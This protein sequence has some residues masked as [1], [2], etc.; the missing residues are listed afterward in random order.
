MKP[1]YDHD[2]I[3]IYHGDCREI[4][5][6]VGQVDCVVTSPPYDNL[7]V[8]GGH[9]FDFDGCASALVPTISEG[10]VIVWVVADEA[11]DGDESGSSMRQAL[12]FKE[13][14]M[15]LHD[16][17]IWRKLNGGANGSNFAYLQCWE[18]M[19]VFSKG[20][21]KTTN[22]IEDRRNVTP[23][24]A[25]R[26]APGRRFADGTVKPDRVV[27]RKEFGRRWNVWDTPVGSDE[28]FGHPAVFPVTLAADHIR[29]WC[30]GDGT[31]LDPFAGSG[32]T[33]RAAKDLGRRAIGIEIE[34]RYCE[35]AAERL[36]QE[37]LAL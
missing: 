37:V 19:F 9:S 34:E 13:L 17:M 16:T 20:A 24:R 36:S 10:G 11:K 23:P 1:Y 30:G 3:T 25:K 21:P 15:R 14:G 8:Y 5:P 26:E 29:S 35:I 18:F 7:R 2:G 22:L 32:S 4:L 12:R 31:V 6:T 28:T 27:V 33:L